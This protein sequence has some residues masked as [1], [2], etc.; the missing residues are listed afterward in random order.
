MHCYGFAQLFG[1]LVF[2]SINLEP[3]QGLADQTASGFCQVK[4]FERV[5]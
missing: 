5:D 2:N 4:T 1:V 3:C